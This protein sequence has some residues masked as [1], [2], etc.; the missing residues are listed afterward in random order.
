MRIRIRTVLVALAVVLVLLVVGGLTAVGWAVVLGPK[1]RPV[2]DR[3]FQA[4]P[5]RLARGRYLAE[6]PAH[7]FHCHSNHD[8]SDP[9][10]PVIPATK[11]A[12]WVMP[13]PELRMI[14]SRNITS[15]VETG[16]GGWTDDEIARAIREG[17]SRDGSALFPLMPYPAFASLS[18][19]DLASIVVYLRTIPPV[20]NRV[21]ARDL[22]FPLSFL[23][24]TM[25]APITEPVPAPPSATPEERGR[26]LVTLATCHGC[27]TPADQG[28]PLPGLDFA[29]G[30]VFHD[31]GQGMKE[32]VSA[33]ITPDPSGIAHYDLDVFRATIR[34]GRL[35]GRT[36][37]HIMPLE[38]F[39]N[40]TDEDLGDIWAH[41]K[42]L[43][44]V[45][46][47]VSNTDPPTLCPRCNRA[48]GLG[49]LNVS[50]P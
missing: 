26:Y 13:I 3:S 44:P 24:N 14:A 39:R 20:R 47:R 21:P 9:T 37:N 29:G 41:V 31:P 7:C 49:E 48:H 19:E 36:L 34:S 40:M 42:T 6:G 30:E 4:T 38:F 15:D 8:F 10:Y 16:L 50:V 46:H 11:G 33:N 17:V 45:R 28:E 27:H 12:G 32:F 23:V 25:P 5:E 22:P 2:T 18:D 1:A 43:T 35:P